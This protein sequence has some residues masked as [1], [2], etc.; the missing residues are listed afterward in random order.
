MIENRN[1]FQFSQTVCAKSS[2]KLIRL[3][4]AGNINHAYS[5]LNIS[6][7]DVVRVISSFLW[8]HKDN[9][10][11]FLLCVQNGWAGGHLLLKKLTLNL[12]VKLLIK[13]F[14]L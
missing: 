1:N 5:L 12:T 14:R 2:G 11:I 13:K 9:Q 7:R 3:K 10:D 6:C 4:T 8:G